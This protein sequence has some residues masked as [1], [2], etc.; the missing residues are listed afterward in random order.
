M[1]KIKDKLEEEVCRAQ[2]GFRHGRG[3]LDHILNLNIFIQKFFNNELRVC[4]IDY[5][6]VFYCEKHQTLWEILAEMGLE[7]T[8]RALMRQLHEDQ[9]AAVK[10]E[11][12]QSEFADRKRTVGQDCVLSPYLFNINTGSI[13]EDVEEDKRSTIY[14]EPNVERIIGMRYADHTALLSETEAGLEQLVHSVKEQSEKRGFQI[15]IEKTKILDIDT[16]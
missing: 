1:K 6:K 14:E 7:P 2:S 4:F 9:Q 3:T 15:N 12:G 8:T 16:C 13:M 5:S 10:L 11:S